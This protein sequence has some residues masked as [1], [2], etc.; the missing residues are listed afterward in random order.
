MKKRFIVLAAC[1]ALLVGMGPA[2]R[3]LEELRVGGGYNELVDGGADFDRNGDIAT[4]GQVTVGSGAIR[5]DDPSDSFVLGTRDGSATVDAIAITQGSPDVAVAGD[6]DAGG[7]DGSDHRVSVTA[8]TDHDAYVDLNEGDSAYG[9]SLWYDGGAGRLHLGTR[10]GA[11]LIDAL[12]IDRGS[13]DVT[14]AGMLKWTGATGQ[15][16][17]MDWR[18]VGASGNV[19]GA[20]LNAY[21]E[22]AGASTAGYVNFTLDQKYRGTAGCTGN[23]SGFL[24]INNPPDTPGVGLSLLR[25][26]V[27]GLYDYDATPGAVTEVRL[28][29]VG[30]F[31]GC[32]AYFGNVYGLDIG[33]LSKGAQRNY[34]IRIGNVGG[35]SIDN[36]A[37]YTGT[38]RVRLGDD[39]SCVGDGSFSGGDVELGTDTSARGVLTCWDGAGGAAPGCVRLCSPDGSPWFL[40]AADDGA[41]R[42]H[43]A[44]PTANSDGSLVGPSCTADLADGAQVAHVDAAETI[45]GAWDFSGAP[46]G[47][48]DISDAITAGKFAGS[49]SVTDAVDLDSAEVAGQLADAKV[50]DTITVGSGGDLSAPPAIGATTPNAG[51]FTGLTATGVLRASTVTVFTADDTTPSVAAGNVFKVPTTWTAGHD[52]TALDDGAAGQIVYVIG[53]D[54]DCAFTDG[55]G[56]QLAG[57]WT[58]SPGDALTLAHDGSGWVELARSDN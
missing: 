57:D 30:Q 49:G 46:L 6:L 36:Y 34:G 24:L 9:G 12:A 20:R 25:G 53:G 1:A 39:L 22:P 45:T 37:I 2:P 44:L 40:F 27:C 19:Y 32:G 5:F 50:S 26:L 43:N 38:G 3:Y 10:D 48:G 51:A 35:G 54:G 15:T 31:G 28:I 23:V 21:P 4:N 18:P 16:L 42:V 58:A 7:A 47:D 41:V 33:A 17:S 11:G 14:L 13:P 29:E 56:L 8:G 55:A 52:V